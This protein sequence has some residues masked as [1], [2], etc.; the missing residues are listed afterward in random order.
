MSDRTAIKFCGL[1]RAADVDVAIAL[2]VDYVG[3]VFAAGSSRRVSIMQAQALVAHARDAVSP[4]Q[5]VALVRDQDRRD[6]GRII[7]AVQPDLIQFHGSESEAECLDIGKPYWKAIGMAG[8]SGMRL[9]MTHASADALVLDAHSAGEAGGTGDTFDWSRWPRTT[10]RLV[11]A[12]GLHAGNV[13][14]AI[15]LTKPF[16]VDVSSGIESAPGIKDRQRMEAFVEAVRRAD[17]A[18]RSV[19]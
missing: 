17:G 10:R 12:G 8:E 7:D 3:L 5:I 1:T 14:K 4:L 13:D 2:G 16:A 19:S 15:T 6:I 18:I 9:A 11:L